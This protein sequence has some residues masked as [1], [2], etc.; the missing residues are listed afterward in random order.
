MNISKLLKFM[1]FIFIIL[2]LLN[3]G[4]IYYFNTAIE[5]ERFA[6]DRQA[7]IQRLATALIDSAEEKTDAARAYV[8]YGFEISYGNYMTE[9]NEAKTGE[10]ILNRL[11]ELDISKD[12]MKHLESAMS[13]YNTLTDTEMRA[14]EMYKNGEKDMALALVTGSSYDATKTTLNNYLK[15]FEN[16]INE[17]AKAYTSQIMVKTDYLF[18]I[19]VVTSSLLVAFVLFTFVILSRKISRLTDISNKMTELSNN[20]GDLTSQLQIKSKDEVGKIGTAFNKMV[21]NLRS[22]ISEVNDT[23]ELVASETKKLEATIMEVSTRMKGI[24]QSV[25]EIT[26]GAEELSATTEEV[27]AFIEEISS[28]AIQLETRA[29]E[30]RKSSQE[31]HERAVAI[32]N[33]SANAMERGNVLY[34]EKYDVIEKAIQQGQVVDEVR[35]MA[36]SIGDIAAQTNLLALNAAIEAARVGEAGKGFAVVADEVRKLAEQSSEAVSKIHSVV[37]KVEAAFKNLSVGSSELLEFLS[38][39]MK[40]SYQLLMNTGD[41]YSKDAEFINK[42]ADEI[43]SAVRTMRESIEQVSGSIQNVSA[44]AEESAAGTEEI[45]G[46]VS[47]SVEEVE[48]LVKSAKEQQEMALKLKELI[49]RFKI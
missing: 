28:A 33:E 29:E 36:D 44:I 2:S 24:N 19:I 46:T 48:G 37:E 11:K 3:G 20:E 6:V 34:E 45:Y 49:S 9:V 21:S 23:T 22:L 32:K 27:N 17:E 41:Q 40:P 26:G 14:I 42:M 47:E 12:S 1:G 5:K 4:S 18:A 38:N 8:Q 43:L 35:I 30:A 15:L 39:E 10:K 7:E 31:I 13:V 16:K 25:E